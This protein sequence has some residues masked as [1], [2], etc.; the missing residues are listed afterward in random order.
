MCLA[1]SDCMAKIKA[2]KCPLTSDLK[3]ALK[4]SRIFNNFFPEV[5]P[6]L[7]DY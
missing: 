5:V 4:N 6:L 7:S 1:G 3:L 2:F